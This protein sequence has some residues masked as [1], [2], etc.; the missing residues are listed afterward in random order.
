MSTPAV[1][2][3]SDA[4]P[5]W[6]RR[7]ER[8]TPWMLAIIVWIAR[9]LGR[10]AARALLLPIV[11]Y[12]LLTGGGARR[13][14]RRFLGVALGRPAR[15][16]DVFRNLYAFAV[17]ALDRVFLLG[18]RH[19]QIDIQRHASPAVMDVVHAGGA[20]LLTAHLGSF[21]ALRV[22]GINRYDM[23]FRIV[24]D[25]AHAP[26]ITGML[27]QLNPAL[28]REVIDSSSGPALALALR[29]ALDRRCVVGMMADRLVGSDPGVDAPFMGGRARL[30]AEPWR[31]AAA[32]GVPVLLCFGLYRGGNHYDLHFELFDTPGAPIPRGERAAYV[33]ASARRF[34]TRLEHYARMAPYNWFNF[35][36][37]WTDERAGD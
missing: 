4:V 8:S 16:V 3:R 5:A 19:R 24:M 22:F 9:H 31:W 14:S 20:L 26:M 11:G 37:F 7:R 1:D 28:A 17:C 36:D 2:G 23:R 12:F 34:A 10:P 29:E 21:D 33:T 32:L 6:K 13:A 25:R 27:E 18:G 30:P 35:F 15:Q